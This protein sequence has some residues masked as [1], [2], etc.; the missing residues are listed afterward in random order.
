MEHTPESTL[1]DVE[2]TL[3]STAQYL[4]R[5]E[6]VQEDGRALLEAA[7]Y[8]AEV[9]TLL[10]DVRAA[11]TARGVASDAESLDQI[12]RVFEAWGKVPA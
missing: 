11:L 3:T 4:G 9:R 8:L 5:V 7:D 10:A 6:E 1:W 12:A 2:F